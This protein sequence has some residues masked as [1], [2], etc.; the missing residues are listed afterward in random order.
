MQPKAKTPLAPPTQM[1]NAYVP[2]MH[3]SNDKTWRVARKAMV[4]G[5]ACG[6]E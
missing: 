5:I 1:D 4:E 2:A 3:A 6:L